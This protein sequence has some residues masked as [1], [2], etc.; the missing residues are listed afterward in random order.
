MKPIRSMSILAPAVALGLMACGAQAEIQ[1]NAR[2]LA[3]SVA[4]KLASA[5]TVRL[6]AKHEL[7]P[8]L[9]VGVGIEKGPL[10]ITMKRPNK[11]HI[12]QK[13]G[14]ETREIAF[15][16]SALCVMHPILKHHAL[17][18]LK[19][20][21]IEQ[22]GDRMEERF[23]F[24]PPVAELLANDLAAHLFVNVTHAQMRD[25]G[26]VGWTRCDCLHLE[27]DGMIA[28]LWVGKRDRLP[29]RLLLIFTSIPGNPAW[30]I[31]LS[32]WELNVPVD[33]RLFS[34]R[35]A[36]DSQKVPMLKSH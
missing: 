9:G 18:P 16:G 36:A 8:R 25:G 27:Q 4:E 2:E 21:S 24:R 26:W 33:E 29:R 10:V 15:D 7:D 28:E 17:E 11:V 19:A 6:I 35:P 22:L 31:R 3:K 14:D 30:N 20:A 12:V 13:A 34:K 23:G 5:Q 32:K 1:P